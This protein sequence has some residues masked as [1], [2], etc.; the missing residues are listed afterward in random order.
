MSLYSEYTSAAHSICNLKYSVPKKIPI[1]F[2]KGYNYDYH[3]SIKE[4]AE[5][6][7]QF[8][9]LGENTKKYITFTVPIQ[10]ADTKIEENTEEITKNKSYILKFIDIAIYM[11]SSLSNLVSNLSEG[12]HKIK[13]KYRHNDKKCQTCRIKYKYWNCFLEY[14]NFK[15]YLIEYEY[16]RCNEKY[17]QKFDG[18]LKEQFFNIYRFSNYDNKKFA[19]RCLPYE[20]MDDCENFNETLLLE[21]EDFY[22]HLNMEYITDED[23]AHAKRICKEFEIET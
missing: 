13:C 12:I 8:A 11:A 16:L 23:Y 6:F 20:Y 22:N 7:K 3:F 17:Q 21:K 10:K 5:E 1:V 15:D 4:L 19:K 18:N 9:C 2:H 14:I